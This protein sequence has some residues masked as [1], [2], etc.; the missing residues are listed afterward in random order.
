MNL[1]PALQRPCSIRSGR[2][3]RTVGPEVRCVREFILVDPAT[4]YLPPGIR[5][6]G[7]DPVKLARQITKH[8]DALD[9]DQAFYSDRT[10]AWICR[11][12]K[13]WPVDC[14]ANAPSRL[15][16]LTGAATRL[17]RTKMSRE[18]ARQFGRGHTFA[19][20]VLP[21]PRGDTGVCHEGNAWKP[22]VGRCPGCISV[23]SPAAGE[24]CTKE[25]RS[26]SRQ[27]SGG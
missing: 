4:L 18:R 15:L 19:R 8:G 27:N 10:L 1:A 22:Y 25:T 5:S 21:A 23:D 24:G 16:K 14:G 6:H 26:E 11:D 12:K 9:G 13:G 3:N 2:Y 7:A 17:F 20:G